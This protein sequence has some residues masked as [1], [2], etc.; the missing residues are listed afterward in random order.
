MLFGAGGNRC[1]PR[2]QHSARYAADQPHLADENTDD[3]ANN[4]RVLRELRGIL[5]EKR[6]GRFVCV[7]AAARETEAIFTVE[8]HSILGGLGTAVAEVLAEAEGVKAPLKRIGVPPAFSPHIG[9]Q[10][11]MLQRYGLTSEAIAATVADT[12][13]TVTSGL[14]FK[15]G[16]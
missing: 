7:L 6:T 3:E 9:S 1:R 5:A 10:D 12:L 2:P 4:A 8:E 15:Q 13:Q 16:S 14:I 11:Y